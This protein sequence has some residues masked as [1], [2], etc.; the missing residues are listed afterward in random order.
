M[1]MNRRFF[2]AAIAGLATQPAAALAL[3]VPSRPTRISLFNAHTGESFS[4]PYRDAEG[5][6]TSAMTDLDAFL[7]DFHSGAETKIDVAVIDFLAAVLSAVGEKKATILSAYRTPATNAMLA[8][9]MFGVA[10][11]SQHMYGRALDIHLGA[12]LEDAMNAARAMKRG[13]VGWYP[14]SHFIHIDSGPVRNWTLDVG[15]LTHL[16]LGNRHFRIDG[17]GIHVQ[18]NGTHLIGGLRLRGGG[19]LTVA[20]RLALHRELAH[21]EYLAR[22]GLRR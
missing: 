4:G 11:N 22:K 9:T 5:P 3:P 12:R 2:L 19:P 21:A 10:E 20:Q 8:R 14:R 6:I 1:A 7:R 16:L 13:G 18:G 17:Y 15:G